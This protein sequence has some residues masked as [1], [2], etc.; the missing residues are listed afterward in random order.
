[1]SLRNLMRCAVALSLA[2]PLCLH[3]E[4]FDVK[5]GAWEV[6]TTTVTTGMVIPPE[7]MARMTPE[8][9]AQAE[10]HLKETSGKPETHVS[11]TC[12]TP[13]RLD[14]D[15][16]I[17]FKDAG[18]CTQK[19]ITKSARKLAV[20]RTCPAPNAYTASWTTEAT[21][22]ESMTSTTDVALPNGGKL[23]MD[24]KGKWLGANCEGIVRK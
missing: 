1:M 20:E 2:A 15:A 21:T 3:A 22:R 5:P 9:R 12:M 24:I 23:H 13:Q 7:A 4:A 19:V 14:Q 17:A 6:T 8:Q 10:K 11:K 18:K 16:L